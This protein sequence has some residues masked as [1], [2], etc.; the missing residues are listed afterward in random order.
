MSEQE[1]ANPRDDAPDNALD[2]LTLPVLPLQAGVVLPQM[3][4]T[5]ALETDEA[6]LAAESAGASTG[7]LLLV[8]KDDNGRYAKVG[9]IATIE[10]RGTLPGGTAAL[11]VRATG[12][13][14]V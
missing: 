7:Q 1:I 4:V 3:V 11:V 13:A 8:P 14:R 5:L 10:D 6:R 12:R 2:R 9:T